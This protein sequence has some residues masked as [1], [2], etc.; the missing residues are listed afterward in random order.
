MLVSDPLDGLFE[1]V[2]IFCLKNFICFRIDLFIWGI[3]QGVM[4]FII[5]VVHILMDTFLLKFLHGLRYE[6]QL[7]A[8]LNSFTCD[9]TW[10]SSVE[11]ELDGFH[12]LVHLLIDG[13]L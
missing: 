2:A 13:V 7:P 5:Y 1:S 12:L 11:Q 3:C 8:F 10:C 6:T 4:D 9:M